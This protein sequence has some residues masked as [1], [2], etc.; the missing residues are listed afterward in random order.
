MV[1]KAD[2][3]GPRAA[4]VA[5]VLLSLGLWS[6]IWLAVSYLLLYAVNV[7]FE[8]CC[9]CG[10]EIERR[11]PDPWSLTVQAFQG[12]TLIWFC[13]AACLRD[14]A[15]GLTDYSDIFESLSG[16]GSGALLT[17]GLVVPRP[18]TYFR[19]GD[20][21]MRKLSMLLLF[22]VALAIGSTV[23][24]PGW[25]ISPAYAEPPDPC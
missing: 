7:T 4:F 15:V 8:P 21:S 2:L 23:A 22:A 10:Q 9:F 18:V 3:L 6:A 1:E 19:S 14:R 25:M 16:S 11:G 20:P 5:I 17:V 12:R 13:Q 24:G